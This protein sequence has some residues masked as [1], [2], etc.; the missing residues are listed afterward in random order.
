MLIFHISSS[1]TTSVIL[2]E[3]TGQVKVLIPVIFTA[4]IA[5]SIAAYISPLGLFETGMEIKKFPYLEHAENKSLD[6]IKVADIMSSPVECIRPKE[7]ARTLVELLQNSS[8]NGFPVVDPIA[9]AFLGLVRRDQI[10]ALLE[11]GIFDDDGP[12]VGL[13]AN[14]YDDDEPIVAAA[15]ASTTTSDNLWSAAQS[16][17]RTVSRSTTSGSRYS[18]YSSDPEY[19]P[20]AGSSIHKSPLLHL[21][22]H[23][24]DDRYD[25]LNLSTRKGEDKT[26]GYK[27]TKS[28]RHQSHGTMLSSS[29]IGRHNIPNNKEST[30]T[31][32]K[33][34]RKHRSRHRVVDSFDQNVWLD[35]VLD[36]LDST[37]TTSQ[38]AV[39]GSDDEN[40]AGRVTTAGG[41]P[42]LDTAE[43]DGL[44]R[45][46]S[47][48][49]S[50]SFIWDVGDDSL[51]PL[52]KPTMPAVMVGPESDDLQK[53]HPLLVAGEGDLEA[54]RDSIHS[55]SSD[56]T[57][58]THNQPRFA[59][60]S[61]DDKGHVLV[62]ELVKE[63]YYSK[64]V[65]VGAVMNLGTYTVT[66]FCPVSKAKY[67]F[68]ALGLRHL[69][70]LGSSAST[71]SVDVASRNDPIHTNTIRGKIRGW[72]GGG[73][74]KVVGVVTRINLLK[75]YIHEKTGVHDL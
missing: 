75:E 68:T 73:G 32:E 33:K 26:E 51:P 61:T 38:R 37:I 4:V 12:Y 24:K 14:E 41:S 39:D 74:G 13:H 30:T 29:S 54:D 46:T 44:L 6:V 36:R 1:T 17:G 35:S 57:T 28:E 43:E 20:K 27:E 2:V 19:T 58:A 23:I 60:V 52:K 31:K 11:C 22:Y 3:G 18:S 21:A 55:I 40:V 70:V 49:N 5:R 8:H 45:T 66:E 69:I 47:T 7:R 64:W 48:S 59:V 62:E 72:S 25:Y 16:S 9:G 50:D 53:V 67:L 65:N 42:E 34:K 56:S 63:E 15:A 71:G 10:V